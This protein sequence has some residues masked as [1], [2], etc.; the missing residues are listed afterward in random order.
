M[1]L[2]REVCEPFAYVRFYL[3]VCWP[4]HFFTIPSMLVEFFNPRLQ[5]FDLHRPAS[6]TAFAAMGSMPSTF[7]TRP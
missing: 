5:F 1:T 4:S 7:N 6:F 3:V 2:Y